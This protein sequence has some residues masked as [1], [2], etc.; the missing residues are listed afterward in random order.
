MVPEYVTTAAKPT[1]HATRRS[2]SVVFGVVANG[3]RRKADHS[4]E[5]GSEKADQCSTTGQ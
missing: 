5:C 4:D 2:G 3:G 1:A